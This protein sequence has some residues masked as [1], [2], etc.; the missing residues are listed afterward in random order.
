MNT[1]VG[2]LTGGLLAILLLGT[3]VEAR[4]QGKEPIVRTQGDQIVLSNDAGC[5]LVLVRKDGQY[6]LGTFYFNDVALGSPIDHF[7]TEHDSGNNAANTFQRVWAGTW[8]SG[9]RATAFEILENSDDRGVIRFS[10][11]GGNPQG[12]VTIALGR[13]STGYR[14]DY[15]MT[16]VK[17]IQAPALRE[18]SVLR[19]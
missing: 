10:G 17:N 8:E 6:G 14:L 13:H 16:A 18:C 15:E 5:R 2:W 19:G 12:S 3:S 1:K 9:F 7:L 4:A 11:R